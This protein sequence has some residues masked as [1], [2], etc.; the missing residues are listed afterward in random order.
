MDKDPADVSEVLHKYGVTVLTALETHW[1]CIV[2]I[3]NTMSITVNA[4]D[5]LLLFLKNFKTKTVL[6]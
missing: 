4:Y 6:K 5:Q 3:L 2:S 1:K